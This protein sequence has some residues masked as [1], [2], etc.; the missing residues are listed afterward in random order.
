MTQLEKKIEVIINKVV[1]ENMP[2]A[3]AVAEI[4]FDV[5]EEYDGE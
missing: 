2:V 3:L 4:M 1:K 5:K